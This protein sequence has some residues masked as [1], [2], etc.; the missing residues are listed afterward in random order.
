[1]GATL[2]YWDGSA[3]VAK[4]LKYWDGSA[5]VTK[6][7]KY[8]S[9]IGGQWVSGPPLTIFTDTFDRA[10]A[11]LEASPTASGGG[12]W[13]HDAWVAGGAVIASNVVRSNTGD[14]NGSGY[15]TPPL[16]SANHYVQYKV[17]ITGSATGPFACCRFNDRTNW[18]G[19]RTGFGTAAGQIEVYKKVSNTLSALYTSATGA[20]VI[21][22]IIRLE[23]N[24]TNFTV[25][26]NGTAV[27]GAIDIPIAAATLTSV[28]TGLIMRSS[29][30]MTFNDF[31]AGIL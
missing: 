12:N 29:T 6:T 21:G 9:A 3:W 26:K 22:D 13:S 18:V 1:M 24:G 4:P 16:S 17:T 11:N 14:T 23:C 15:K 2:K 5:W 19:I 8:W 10:N 20:V 28:G 27:T 30:T 25:K 7:L 31:E